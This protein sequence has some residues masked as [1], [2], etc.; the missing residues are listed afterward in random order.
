MYKAPIKLDGFS[1]T[2][3]D[4]LIVNK[5][6]KAKGLPI[7]RDANWVNFVK[8]KQRRVTT[9]RQCIVNKLMCN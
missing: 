3:D 2:R 8:A 4:L 7:V 1:I 5:M 9:T 6:R